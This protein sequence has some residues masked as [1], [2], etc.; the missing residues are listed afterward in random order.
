LTKIVKIYS[1]YKQLK[2]QYTRVQLISRADVTA[3]QSD[4]QSS[5]NWQ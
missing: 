5:D 4:V 2:Y 1:I 3:G